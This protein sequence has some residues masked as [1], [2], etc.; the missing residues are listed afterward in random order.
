MRVQS[1]QSEYAAR[2][3]PGS[4]AARSELAHGPDSRQAPTQQNRRQTMTT[5]S[6]PLVNLNSWETY[7]VSPRYRN[8][9][10]ALIILGLIM[11]IALN[12]GRLGVLLN[13]PQGWTSTTPL[14]IL[15]Q[16]QFLVLVIYTGLTLRLKWGAL[17]TLFAAMPTA[18]ILLYAYATGPAVGRD[19]MLGALTQESLIAS[20]GL[21]MVLL[22][23]RGVRQRELGLSLAIQL[24]ESQLQLQKK[25]AEV[26]H[27]SRTVETTDRQLHGL[28][29]LVRANLNTLYDDL[30]EIV[31]RE[32]RQIEALPL[33]LE[34]IE[35]AESLQ[36]VSM[37]ISTNG[38]QNGNGAFAGEATRS[39]PAR[40]GP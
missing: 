35:F 5:M 27:L 9:H 6:R 20:A 18:P 15:Y 39:G 38:R 30:R 36:T 4:L 3:P 11:N 8:V 26:E 21:V 40:E 28:N 16:A 22:V 17:C 19:V 33:S 31:Q 12:Y 32:Q 1:Q 37:V 14:N 13:N 25:M 10:I 2:T 23:E 7:V 34:K 29:T 24:R